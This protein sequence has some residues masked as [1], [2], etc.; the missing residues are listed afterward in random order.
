MRQLDALA[1]PRKQHRVVT[2][3][4]ATADGGKANTGGVTLAGHALTGIHGAVFQITP[5]RIG[6]HFTHFEGGARRRIHLVAM[7]RLNDFDVVA[8]RHGFGCHFKQ[9]EGHV[10]THTHIGR[11]HDGKVFGNLCN[12]CFLRIAETGG[13][14]DRLHP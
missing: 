10:D 4:V 7:V 14:N 2:H 9:L 13:A 5:E 6:N 12:L 8:G 3:N 11:H 1:R